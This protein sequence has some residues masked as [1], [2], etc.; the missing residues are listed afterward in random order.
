[1]RQQEMKRLEA[2]KRAAM[3][4]HHRQQEEEERKRREAERKD[5]ERREAERK[6]KERREAENEGG[7]KGGMQKNRDPGKVGCSG[8]VIQ[9]WTD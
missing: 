2:E 7:R 9:D 5:T 3:D 6:D 1:M 4:A 8:G